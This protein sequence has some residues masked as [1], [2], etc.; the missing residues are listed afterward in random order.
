MQ[1][2]FTK[3][4][5]RIKKNIFIFVILCFIS[6][7]INSEEIPRLRKAK[8]LGTSINYTISN[9]LPFT[10]LGNGDK[11]ADTM[12]GNRNPSNNFS[13]FYNFFDNQ[14]LGIRIQHNKSNELTYAY[15][16]GIIYL[17]YYN[18]EI[19]YKTPNVELF[20]KFYIFDTSF[21]LSP[22]IGVASPK[23]LTSILERTTPYLDAKKDLLVPYGIQTDVSARIY[24]GLDLGYG[25]TFFDYFYINLG[26]MVKIATNPKI[27]SRYYLGLTE[28]SDYYKN[29][30]I[31]N[32]V[33]SSLIY[34]NINKNFNEVR[35]GSSSFYIEVGIVF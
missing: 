10:R 16:F 17:G 7:N 20:Y 23:R 12:I 18:Q 13:L 3:S 27:R 1:L 25:F 15:D 29:F 14:S 33:Y 2:Y 5:Y 35:Q 6:F 11:Y 30:Q 24:G 8:T 34:S 31:E 26:Y 9:R 22:I 28:I 19:K 32:S 21:Y 4:N